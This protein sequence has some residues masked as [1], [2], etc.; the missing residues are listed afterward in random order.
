VGTAASAVQPSAARLADAT[1][2]DVDCIA[3]REGRW[4]NRAD[5]KGWSRPSRPV[6]EA[7]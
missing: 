3:D 1:V 4:N 6:L 5:K 2:P 7:Q